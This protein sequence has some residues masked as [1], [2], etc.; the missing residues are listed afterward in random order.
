MLGS[1]ESGCDDSCMRGARRTIALA[2][3]FGVEGCELKRGVCPESHGSR[4]ERSPWPLRPTGRPRTGPLAEP[5]GMPLVVRGVDLRLGC[6]PLEEANHTDACRT[7]REGA[8]VETKLSIA[9]S[10]EISA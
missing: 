1:F 6:H 7:F 4:P 8:E 10:I 3:G 2:S 9:C 5:R